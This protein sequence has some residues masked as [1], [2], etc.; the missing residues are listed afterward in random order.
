MVLQSF[1]NKYNLSIHVCNN[2]I[3]FKFK[4]VKIK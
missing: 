3:Q 2:G 4:K 1:N